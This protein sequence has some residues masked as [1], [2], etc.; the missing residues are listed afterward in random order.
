VIERDRSCLLI[1]DLQERLLPAIT[2]GG[3]VVARARRLVEA[4]LRL[5]VPLLAT[6]QYPAGLGPLAAEIR[7]LLPPG[8]IIGKSCFNAAAEAGFRRRVESLDRR[9]IVVAGAEA[10]VCVQQTSLGLRALGFEVAVVVDA[11]GT[12]RPLDREVALRR[13][14]AHGV[15]LVTGEMVLFEWLGRAPSPEFRDLLP[16]IR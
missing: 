8:S 11:V 12:R 10:H 7:N 9:Q 15:D 6:E 13:L 16:L 1:I 4:A 14:A 3:A 5:A 2:G